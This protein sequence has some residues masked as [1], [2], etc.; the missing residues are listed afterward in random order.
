[1]VVPGVHK[2]FTLIELMVIIAMVAIMAAIAV[3]SFTQFIDNNRTLSAHNELVSLLQ[4]ARA[5]AVEHRAS[6]HICVSNGVITVK[7]ACDDDIAPLRTLSGTSGVAIKVGATDI[8]FRNNGTAAIATS[9]VTCRNNDW[10]NGFTATVSATG[11]VRTYGR[12]QSATGS[13]SEC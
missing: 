3:P 5:H 11:I 6:T 2:G 4:Y 12:G 8:E 9:F 7:P 13:M 10:A 1:M